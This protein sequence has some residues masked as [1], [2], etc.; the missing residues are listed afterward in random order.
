MT[1]PVLWICT[2]CL[3]VAVHLALSSRLE[4]QWPQYG[5]PNRDFVVDDT[6]LA[7][8]WPEAGPKRLWKRAFG[9]GYACIAAAGGRLFSMYRDGE[10]EYTV[11]IRPKDG[12]TLWQH[13]HPSPFTK[14]MSQFGPG[15]HATPLAAGD[16]VYS[17]GTNGMLHCL[18][19]GDGKVLWRHDLA[20]EY[21]AG[22]RA[23]GYS[24]SPI[25]YKDT[26]IVLWFCFLS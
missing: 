21:G 17:V 3:A 20:V 10:T 12:K 1:K 11:A 8:R 16:R 6:G 24:C 19:A 9:D 25:A 26:V 18:A 7:K 13:A 5:G 15:P 23:R 2:A 4:A 22:I 14:V